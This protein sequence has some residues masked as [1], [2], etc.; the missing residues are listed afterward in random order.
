MMARMGIQEDLQRARDH[1]AVGERL[2]DKQRDLVAEL[3][4]DGHDTH[5]AMRLLSTLE[6]ALSIMRE[7]LALEERIA[8][9]GSA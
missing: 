2:V 4:R 1:V 8:Q 6:Q 5:P 9:E 3:A 7:H